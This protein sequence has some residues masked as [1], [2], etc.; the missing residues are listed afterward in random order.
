MS[1][2]FCLLR[3]W[4]QMLL[5]KKKKKCVRSDAGPPTVGSHP[6]P[7]GGNSEHTTQLSRGGFNLTLAYLGLLVPV[8]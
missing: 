2:S 1:L 6:A 4:L 5:W 7:V 3:D 8:S